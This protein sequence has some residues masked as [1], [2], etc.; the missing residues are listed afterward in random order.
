M[1]GAGIVLV[2]LVALVAGTAIGWL[3][4]AWR[5]RA[6]GEARVREVALRLCEADGSARAG[7]ATVAE[8]RRSLGALEERA[9]TLGRELAAAQQGR[10]VAETRNEELRRSLDEQQALLDTAEQ[11]LVDS[12]RALAA[13]ALAANNEGFLALAAAKLSAARQD[14]EAVLAARQTAIDGLLQP[15]KESLDRVDAKIQELERERGQAYGRLTELV[16]AL[17]ESHGKLASETGNLVR[18]LRAPATRG[19]WGEIQLRR[20]VELAGMVERCDF[21]EQATLASDDGRLR[22]DMIVKLPGGRQVVVDAKVP[23]EAYLDALEAESEEG[24]HARLLRHAEQIRAH[25]QKLSAKSYWAELPATPEFVV[26]FLPSEAMYSA[27][28]QAM[29]SLIEEGVGKQ[30]LI[31]TPT[32]LIALLHAVHSGWRQEQLAENAQAISSQGRELHARLAVMVGHWAK[33]GMALEKATES[34]NQAV[35]SFEGRVAPAIRKLEDLGARSDKTVEALPLVEAR[36]RELVADEE[37]APAL[38]ARAGQE[39]GD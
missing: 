14:T 29:P 33:L 25:V 1:A 16:R 35:A 6:R 4:A 13:Q 23:L 30:V 21:V 12:F 10:A 20:V 38:P 28:L 19:R 39:R 36:P 3:L 7:Q 2:A 17:S 27:A 9:Q 8:L 15:V 37:T 5:E 31:A 22:P 24:R 18:A 32:T 26:M 34:Y 11:K